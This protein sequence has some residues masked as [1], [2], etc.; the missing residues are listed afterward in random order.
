MPYISE[1]L[2]NKITDSTE[3]AVGKL[4]DIL[5]RPKSGQHFPPLEFLEVQKAQDKETVYVPYEFVA[6]FTSSKITLKT[7]FNK[8]ALPA[9][10]ESDF[11]CLKRD[12]LDKQIVDVAGTRV[13]RVN[14]LRIGFVEDKMCVLG[15]DPSFKGLLR[16]LNLDETLLGRPFKVKLIDWRQAELL[17]GTSGAPLQLKTVSENLSHLHP[18]DLANIVEELDIKHG[19]SLLVSLDVKEA[20]KVLEELDPRLQKILVKYLGPE[21]ASKIISQMSTDEFTDLVKSF[22]TQEAGAFLAKI[23]SLKT[24]R[25]EQLIDYPDN[26]AGGL[27][28]LDFVSVRPDW[29]VGQAVEE[30]RKLS[31]GFRSIVFIYVIDEA[32]KFYGVVSLR[33]LLISTPETDISQIFK[34]LPLISTLRP[35]DKVEKIVRIMTKYNLF[36]AAVVDDANKLV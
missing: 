15:I 1:L 16:R 22:S 6:N 8:I 32:G 33:R 17:N 4:K 9:L 21:A 3:S 28:T 30:I 13:V 26:T 2:D 27:M 14:D 31:S 18:A 20:A 35:K 7:I 5:I 19:S 25:V 24:K 36:T 29:K 23:D 12:V 10:P 11:I 34:A